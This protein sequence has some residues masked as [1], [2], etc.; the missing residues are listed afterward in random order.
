VF[1]FDK[2]KSLSKIKKVNCPVLVI[3]G[4]KDEVVAFWHGERFFEMAGKSKQS[5][6]VEGAGH[7]N[8]FARAESQYKQALDEFVT[9][10]ENPN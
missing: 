8:L 6:W 9:L 7:N 5:L 2:F 4:T 1:P 3:H 10:I